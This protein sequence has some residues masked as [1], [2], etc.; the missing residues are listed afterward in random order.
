MTDREW[1]LQYLLDGLRFAARKPS[2][3]D[4]AYSS[5]GEFAF[6]GLVDNDMDAQVWYLTPAGAALLALL[7]VEHCKRRIEATGVFAWT[8]NMSA[9]YEHT[10]PVLVSGVGPLGYQMPVSFGKRCGRST[11]ADWRAAAEYA[12]AH[13]QGGGTDGAQG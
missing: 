4:K 3:G 13:A 2:D 8:D 9:E 11:V 1:E 12:E 5:L 10:C 6:A 7:E